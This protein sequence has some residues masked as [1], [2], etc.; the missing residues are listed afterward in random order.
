MVFKE[1]FILS[2]L[3]INLVRS[4]VSLIK[5]TLVLVTKLKSSIFVNSNKPSTSNFKRCPDFSIESISRFPWVSICEAYISE[6]KLAALIMFA[7][8]DFKSC[9]AIDANFSS[10]RFFCTN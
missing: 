2:S 1:I 3:P 10:S 8:G 7:N 9:A 6:N 5:F 4:F